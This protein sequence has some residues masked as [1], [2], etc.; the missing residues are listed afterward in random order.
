[1]PHS[2]HGK[3][4][5]T[6]QRHRRSASH[7]SKSKQEQPRQALNTSDV[8]QPPTG[9]DA[10]TVKPAAE[11]QRPWSPWIPG[12]DGR[13]FYQGRLKADGSKSSAGRNV[14]VNTA[15]QL[16]FC[17]RRMGIPIHRGLS[18]STSATRSELRDSLSSAVT[19]INLQS[20]GSSR[21]SKFWDRDAPTTYRHGRRWR[22]GQRQW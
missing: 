12:D 13:W 19:G 11:Q 15:L 22:R 2:Q 7:V 3:D 6:K 8:S 4:S 1:M 16:N 20:T 9:N 10:P 5:N 18:P 14:L 17:D 21:R